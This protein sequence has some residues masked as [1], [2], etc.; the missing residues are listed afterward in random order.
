MKSI[1]RVRFNDNVEV[2]Y[3][4]KDK[5]ITEG[6]MINY[7]SDNRSNNTKTFLYFIL[8]AIGILGLIKIIN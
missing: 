2:R 8:I 7:S 5:L 6:N 4:D 3:Y 1:K